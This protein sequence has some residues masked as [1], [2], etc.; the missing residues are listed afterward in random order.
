MRETN[1][2]NLQ[3]LIKSL[4]C[5]YYEVKSVTCAF[6]H[7][8]FYLTDKIIRRRKFS[9]ESIMWFFYPVTGCGSQTKIS[10]NGIVVV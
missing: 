2:D 8:S 5:G 7:L 1:V 4:V 9:M 10:K 3:S 6:L